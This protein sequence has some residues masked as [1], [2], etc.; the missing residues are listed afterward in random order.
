MSTLA[1]LRDSA[2]TTPD[3][4]TVPLAELYL[5]EL[6]PRRDADPEGIALLADSIRV[7]GLIQNLSGVRDAE[8]RVGIVAGGRRFRALQLLAETH[9]HLAEERA[10]IVAVPVRIPPDEATARG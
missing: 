2:L 6:N 4:Q 10:E 7:L 3:V 5:S 8:G 1:E 9:P